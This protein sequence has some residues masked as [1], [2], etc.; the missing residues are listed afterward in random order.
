MT[1]ARFAGEFARM[2]ISVRCFQTFWLTALLSLQTG[3]CADWPQWRGPQRTGHV[4]PGEPV[5]DKLPVTP[6]AL[7]RLKVGEGLASPV[8]AAGKIFYFDAEQGKETLHA[9]EADSSK[10][11]WKATIDN[12]FGDTQGPAGPRCTPVVDGNRIYALSCQGELQCRGITDG[13]LI[14]RTNFTNDFG[15]VF[16][17]EK[18]N[19]AGAA[20]HGNNGSPLIMGERLYAPVGGTNGAG[21]VCFD[22]NSGRV[23]WKSQNDPAAY[24]PPVLATLAGITQ[25]ICFT[26]E[27][28]IGLRESDGALLWRVSMKTTFGRH[29][30]TPVAFED[31]VVVASHQVGLVGTKIARAESGLKAEQIWLHKDLA[32]NFSSPVLVG[33][34]LY[35]LGPN[36]NL[37]CVDVATG[38]LMWS[39]EGYFNTSADKAHA[40]FL[41]M[42]KNVLTL[43][44]GGELILIEANPAE[45]KEHSRVQVCGLNW[46]NPAYVGGTLFVRDGIKTTGELLCLELLAK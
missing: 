38:K 6:K 44:D 28:L 43:T 41:V 27:G 18:G 22:K 10:E 33:Q 8:V 20:R 46:C 34:H 24:P 19:A 23:I 39:K 5:P 40:A 13:K 4:P 29:V 16:I 2:L 17:G 36:K 21:V 35:G 11:L 32:I 3:L 7:W 42:G 9:I 14:W 37:I 30:T 31:I 26:V 45:F 1:F 12:A 15:A 25:V